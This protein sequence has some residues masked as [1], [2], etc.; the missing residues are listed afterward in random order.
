[1][2]FTGVLSVTVVLT[3]PRST[4]TVSSTIPGASVEDQLPTISNAFWQTEIALL[5]LNSQMSPESFDLAERHPELKYCTVT[6]PLPRH[7]SKSMSPSQITLAKSFS[8]L[9]VS[10]R[11][12]YSTSLELVLVIF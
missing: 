6:P 3:G 1:M 12:R 9:E 2:P 5:W 11:Q 10:R 7:V 8:R 4:D